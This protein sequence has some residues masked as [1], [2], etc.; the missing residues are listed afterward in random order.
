MKGNSKLKVKSKNQHSLQNGSLSGNYS[1]RYR[2]QQAIKKYKIDMKKIIVGFTIILF[3]FSC[4][5][6]N[7]NNL[8]NW[9]KGLWI[10]EK[11]DSLC[12][13][14]FLYINNGPPFEFK[15][16]NDSLK[17]FP[18]WS[19]N[20]ND[21]SSYKLEIN[22]SLEEICIYGFSGNEKLLLK[23]HTNECSYEI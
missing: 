4:D 9:I 5:N 13:S 3:I 20:L 10:S 8:D 17:I 12:F 23:R 22:K 15:I 2:W 18:T 19:S 11:Q 1:C 21:W 16:V 6:D 14:T 7:N